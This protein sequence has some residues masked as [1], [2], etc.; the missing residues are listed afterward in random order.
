[1]LVWDIQNPFRLR[2]LTSWFL[3]GTPCCFGIKEVTGLADL[4]RALPDSLWAT[5]G[6]Y[7]HIP[8]GRRPRCLKQPALTLLT[9]E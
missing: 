4:L 9:H 1:M 2:G 7:L 8:Q 6:L 3:P 5:P